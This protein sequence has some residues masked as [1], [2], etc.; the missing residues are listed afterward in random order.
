MSEHSQPGTPPLGHPRESA[1]ARTALPSRPM[2]SKNRATTPSST[3]DSIR[4]SLEQEIRE[5]RRGDGSAPSSSRNSPANDSEI[6]TKTS[7][8]EAS[9]SASKNKRLSASGNTT[10]QGGQVCS[11]C[12]TTRTPLWRRSPQGATICNACGLYLKARNASR[13]TSLKKPPSVV[14]S[15]TSQPGS[16]KSASASG[17]KLLPNVAGATYVAADQTMSGTCPGGGRC[18]G[19]GG[20]EGCNGCPAY[21]NRM[22][23]SAH[24]NVVQR[25]GSCGSSGAEPAKTE[26]IPIDINALQV[27]DRETTVVVACQNCGTTI[28]PLWRR[29]ESGHTICN[30]C[31][32]YY[33]LHGVHRPVTMKKATIKRRKRVIPAAENEEDESMELVETQSQERTPERGTMNEDGSI[34]L[35]FR[36][37]AEHPMTIEPEPVMRTS[38]NT[39]PLPSASDLAAYHQ[40]TGSLRNIPTPLN[41]ENRLAPLTSMAVPP[42]TD[43]RQPSLSPASFLSPTRKRSFSTTEAESVSGTESINDS[44]KRVSSIKSILNPSM[45]ADESPTSLHFSMD[46]GD[47]SLPP[48]R[49]SGSAAIITGGGSFTPLNAPSAARDA[50]VEAAGRKKEERR[51]ALKMEAEQMRELLAAKERELMELDE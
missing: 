44:A 22:S 27:Q 18:N 50:N 25:Q 33:K 10:G 28:T 21:N 47:Y 20:A 29:D 49:S 14:S 51:T 12:G 23:K 1:T 2:S 7:S 41:D 30:A 32:L 15:G 17:T 35:G 31:G 8:P 37:R 13:P 26:P 5:P 36:R 38:G 40:P 39:S 24:F 43:D 3:Q 42:P 9:S 4:S 16:S 45:S 34:N 6:A 46:R 19:T 48:I 11:N